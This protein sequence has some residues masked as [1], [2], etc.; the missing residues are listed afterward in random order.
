MSKLA[1][2]GG[3]PIRTKGFPR[4][5]T[6]GSEEKKAVMEVMDGGL[7]SD[8]LGKA[9]DK[10]LGGKKVRELE[11]IVQD[12]FQV[13]HAVTMNSATSCLYAAVG[14]VGLGVGDEVVVSPYSMCVSATAPFMYQALPVFADLEPD[15]FCLDPKS[16]A[17]NITPKTR[18]ILSVDT[19]G[20]SADM[21]ALRSLADT[22][23]LKIISDSAH[24][25][26]ARHGKDFAGTLADVGV[27]SLNCHKIIQSGEG[28][29]AVTNDDAIALKLRL[30]RNHAEAVVADMPGVDITNMLGQNYRMGEIEA[31]IAV[32]QMKKL[33]GLNAQRRE[34]CE[35]LSDK[36][37]KIPGITPPAVRPGCDH[38]YYLFPV[39][40][41]AAKVGVSRERFLEALNA[42]GIPAFRFTGGYVKPLYYEPV[43]QQKKLFPKGMPFS[44]AHS[45]AS[46]TY[47]P[48]SSPV[49][50][51]L[52]NEEM[53]V[54][55]LI[56]PPLAIADMDDIADAFS[57]IADHVH[58][59]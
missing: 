6:I 13:K 12:K 45:R 28:G 25:A 17:A 35:Y 57:K 31:A 50:E 7:L 29:I 48:E 33:D 34:L 41:D 56:Y 16:V 30:I 23:G 32:E 2:K 36:L 18:A 22:H 52:Y 19:F 42:E 59:L 37:S 21:H 46:I 47:G 8:F 54:L 58:E 26:G 20:Q 39:R 38:V 43:F 15:Y 27:Y 1:L 11:E 14:A 53:V 3:T 51:R 40:Y 24:C 9:G 49:V 44:S 5:N 55:H 4:Y 10:F